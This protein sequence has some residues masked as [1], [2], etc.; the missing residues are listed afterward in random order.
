[1][2]QITN[3]EI[4]LQTA[5]DMTTLYRAD[6]PANFPICETF[7]KDA[8]TR[9]LATAGCVS[10]RI[11]Y[12]MKADRNIDAI[13]VAVNAAGEDILPPASALAVSSDDPII[14]ED[15]LRCPDD[16]PPSSSVNS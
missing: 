9:L 13:L 6:R 11:Y 3:H 1:M 12:G 15:G 4:S 10:F 7:S 16:C 2:N 5:V 14:L 8:I